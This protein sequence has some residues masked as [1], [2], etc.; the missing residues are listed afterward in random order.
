METLT[1]QEIAAVAKEFLKLN[2]KTKGI[3]VTQDG[4]V[5]FEDAV[6]HAK[7]HSRASGFEAPEFFGKETVQDETINLLA[8]AKAPQSET[9]K[10][11]EAAKTEAEAAAK[12]EADK[13]AE[14]AE[15]AEESAKA[16]AEA[17][18]KAEADKKAEEAAKA[19]AE[20]EAAAKALKVEPDAAKKPAAKTRTKK[21]TSKTNPK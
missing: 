7:N 9:G 11:L 14:E 1:K 15:K 5:F 13:K 4:T 2:S 10:M 6:D 8:H 18:A 16:E 3:Y 17:A 21:S 19:E 20:A 12:A